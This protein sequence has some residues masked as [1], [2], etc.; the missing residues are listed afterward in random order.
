M[1]VPSIKRMMVY[2]CRAAQTISDGDKRNAMETKI[3]INSAYLS[4]YFSLLD[5]CAY[6]LLL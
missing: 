6:I 5:G 3:L 2:E 4:S 1:P